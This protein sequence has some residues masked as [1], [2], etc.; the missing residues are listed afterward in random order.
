[1]EGTIT[2]WK[3]HQWLEEIAESGWVS[4]HYDTPALS[5]ED[6]AEFSGGGYQ[7]YKM[8]WSQPDNRAIWSMDDAKF[9]GLVRNR[10]TYFGIWNQ[11]NKGHLVAYTELKEPVQVLQGKGFVIPTGQIAVSLG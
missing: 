10:I 8:K 5:G 4:L 9:T 3:V 11:K 2:D 1:M 7:R 6:K